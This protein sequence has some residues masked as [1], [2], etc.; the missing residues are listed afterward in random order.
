VAES[1]SVPG[2][3]RVGD[4]V[5]MPDASASSPWRKSFRADRR[6]LPLADRHYN[7]QSVGSPQFVPPGR[8]YV[9]LS[10]NEPADALW[11]TSW[12]KAEYVKHAWAGAWMNSMFRRE[13]KQLPQASDLIRLAVAHTLAHWPEPP[14]LG[15]VTFVDERHT[16]R[17]RSRRKD[18]GECYR[19]A[20]FR[21][22][23]FTK[24]GLW[25]FQMLP[26]EMPAPLAVPENG[27][28]FGDEVAA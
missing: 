17:R 4:G 6:A 15:M 25:A 23:G 20:G 10:E 22:V 19:Q 8:C 7:R 21:H 16:G 13:G 2:V 27:L 12:P 18:P 1:P 9:L 28:P 3:G 14:D 24:A 11:V 5:T 26:S